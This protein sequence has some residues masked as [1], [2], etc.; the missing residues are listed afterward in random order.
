MPL[1]SLTVKDGMLISVKKQKP[2]EYLTFIGA[3][4]LAG[5]LPLVASRK[6]TG[7]ARKWAIAT[8]VLRLGGTLLGAGVVLG[9]FMEAQAEAEGESA[10]TKAEAKR[11]YWSKVS[12]VRL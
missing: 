4:L 11:A 1:T 6:L 8:A 7:N 5:V 9:K 2:A 10:E 3:S 12:E